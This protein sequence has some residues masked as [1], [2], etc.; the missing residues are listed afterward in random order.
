M[1]AYVI[2][3]LSTCPPLT[4]PTSVHEG[5]L[6]GGRELFD[7]RFKKIIDEIHSPDPFNNLEYRWE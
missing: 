7:L 4:I 3:I 1:V 5:T 6:G 2:I